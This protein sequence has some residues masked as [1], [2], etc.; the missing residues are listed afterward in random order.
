MSRLRSWANRRLRLPRRRRGRRAHRWPCRLR[1][2]PAQGQPSR[3]V[4]GQ[5]YWAHSKLQIDRSF[6][7][8]GDG[9]TP[10]EIRLIAGGPIGLLTHRRIPVADASTFRNARDTIS[11]REAKIRTARNRLSSAPTRFTRQG[12]DVIDPAVV[13]PSAIA[14]STAQ[15]ST[16]STVKS[17]K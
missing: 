3:G 12:N 16:P 17:A 13:R 14:R 5:E 1:R 11:P 10:H 7:L 15:P 2:C 4:A 8:Q 6:S 9:P